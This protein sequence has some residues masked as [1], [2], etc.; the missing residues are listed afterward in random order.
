MAIRDPA[1]Y[2]RALQTSRTV[3]ICTPGRTI[4]A[5]SGCLQSAPITHVGVPQIV[6]LWTRTL[7]IPAYLVFVTRRLNA[8]AAYAI[9]AELVSVTGTWR[10][11]R[12][13][14]QSAA[15][16]RLEQVHP[17]LLAMTAPGQVQGDLAHPCRT[18]RAA[19]AMR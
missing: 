5:E 15:C 12:Y 7:P 14:S 4:P 9:S 13:S 10:I 2:G 19:M 3:L 11:P 6:Q 16:R 8:V 18:M 1:D 17:F